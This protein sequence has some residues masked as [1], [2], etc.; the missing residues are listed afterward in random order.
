MNTGIEDTTNTVYKIVLIGDSG[1]GK[2]NLLQ[3]FTKDKF[4]ADYKTTLGVEFDTKTLEIAGHSVTAQIWDTA[5]Q[6]R[7]RSITKAYYKEAVAAMVVYDISKRNSFQSLEKWL[8][9]LK[10]YAE[11]ILVIGLV[12]NK[13]DLKQVRSISTEEGKKF[14]D[15]NDMIFFETSALDATNVDAAFRGLVEGLFYY[16][17]SH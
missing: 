16:M 17:I 11:G 3:R 9:E 12:G 8:K 7:Y 2:T 4:A 5:G 15:D 6:E 10:D 13:C 14:A 1:V